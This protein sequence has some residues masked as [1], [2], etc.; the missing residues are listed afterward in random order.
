MANSAPERPKQFT[1]CPVPEPSVI[2]I[3]S[4]TLRCHLTDQLLVFGKA[5]FGLIGLL[6]SRFRDLYVC[7]LPPSVSF[8]ST[9][10]CSEPSGH[11]REV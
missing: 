5:A 4:P 11:F 10:P 7:H 2:L 6:G 3:E 8:T 9:G 1:E